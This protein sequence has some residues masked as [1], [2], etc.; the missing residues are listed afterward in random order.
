M[1]SKKLLG[2]V[3]AVLLLGGGV[4]TWQ[5]MK[6]RPAKA[7][8]MPPIA[9]LRLDSIDETNRV[10]TLSDGGSRDPDGRL[11]SWRI[12][13]GDSKE[14]TLAEIPQKAPHTYES[15]GEYRISFS[16]VDNLGATSPPAITNIT[17]DFEKRQLLLQ[18]EA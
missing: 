12:A 10:V 9:V 2:I 18:A 8:N 13:W 14:D 6:S 15:E 16:C 3:I 11:K 5:V 1:N 17:F 4:A 7:P